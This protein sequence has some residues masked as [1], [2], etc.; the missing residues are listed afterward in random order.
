MG[1]TYHMIW[2]QNGGGGGG[3]GAVPEYKFV[4]YK[5]KSEFVTGQAISWTSGFCLT[6]EHLIMNFSMLFE[7]GPL[8]AISTLYPPDVMYMINVP[9]HLQEEIGQVH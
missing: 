2:I 8:L 4:H 6:M 9:P 3:E 5:H 1:N 7:Y